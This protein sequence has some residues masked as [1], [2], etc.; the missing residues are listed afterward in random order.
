MVV[1]T[2]VSNI[3]LLL[4]QTWP[5]SE[6]Q[7]LS[8][9]SNIP[10]S[11]NTSSRAVGMTMSCQLHPSGFWTCSFPPALLS[12][13]NS[14][15]YCVA[16]Q[17]VSL[18]P[19]KPLS[20]CPH[21]N[22]TD[23]QEQLGTCHLPCIHPSAPFHALRIKTTIPIV[24]EVLYGLDPSPLHPPLPPSLPLSGLALISLLSCSDIS[25]PW[26]QAL[27]MC[28]FLCP[29]IPSLLSPLVH[30]GLP[31]NITLSTSCWAVTVDDPPLLQNQV[32]YLI[33]GLPRSSLP[34]SGPLSSVDWSMLV[35]LTFQMKHDLGNEDA[36]PTFY[37]HHLPQ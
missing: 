22:Q 6:I 23:L 5:S 1:P 18:Y 35:T 28:C 25:S 26:P 13:S 29:E 8:V 34:S 24:H 10:P 21:L 36:Q 17:P 7:Y 19:F 9:G 30:S 11:A 4:P 33:T 2:D 27:C 15:S 3:N 20:P 37:P 31:S 32:T 16:S 14:A 12:W